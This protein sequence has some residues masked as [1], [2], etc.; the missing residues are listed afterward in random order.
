MR[1]RLPVNGTVLP[2][3]LVAAA[4]L[5]A[6]CGSASG[7]GGA[8]TLPAP[9]GAS[10]SAGSTSTGG[11]SAGSTAG[12]CGDAFV[13]LALPES[14]RG[15]VCLKVGSTLRVRNGQAAQAGTVTGDALREVTAGVY[16]GVS[17]GRA[18]LGGTRRACPDEPGR[19]S[20]MSIVHW[21]LTVDVR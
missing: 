10:T 1:H 5:A 19:M 9:G 16:L 11:T 13:D 18:E 17:A 14:S 21:D 6:G 4:L 8:R 20:C 12:D 3:V 7:P 2:A 15:T